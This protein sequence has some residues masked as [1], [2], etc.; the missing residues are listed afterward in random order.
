MKKSILGITLAL[1]F[2]IS[3]C[4]GNNKNANDESDTTSVGTNSKAIQSNVDTNVNKIGTET[5]ESGGGPALD[6]GQL[7]ANSDCL[8]CHKE[9]QKIIGPSYQDVAA[10]YEATEEN[11]NM[12]AGKIIKGGSGVWGEIPM[13]AHPQISENDAKEM[14]KYILAL[15]K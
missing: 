13:T 4:G 10:K 1:A 5:Q 7:I 3:A 15:K 9:N 14:V 11:I 12:L 6:G 2:I 8:S